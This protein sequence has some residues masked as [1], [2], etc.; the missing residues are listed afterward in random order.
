M[1]QWG[2]WAVFTWLGAPH[3]PFASP[4]AHCAE[5]NRE[6]QWQNKHPSCPRSK[7]NPQHKNN[8]NVSEV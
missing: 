2:R 6:A 8:K 5:A 7:I 3:W 4:C 1:G